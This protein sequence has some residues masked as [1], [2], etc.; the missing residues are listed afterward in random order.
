M[1]TDNMVFV[2][3][4]NESGI[5]G[6]GAA[7]FALNH[8]GAASGMGFGPSSYSFAIP[9]KDW[10]VLTL[11]LAVIEHYVNRFIVYAR[12]NP[13]YEFQVTAIGCGLAGFKHRQIAPLFKYAPDNCFFD[14]L[15]KEFLP[16]KKFW[17]TF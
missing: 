14:T 17:G 1:N 6:A 16:D 5:H 10:R 11:P 4:S 9:T 2:F 13:E 8:K 7:R 3:G 15:W 12:K